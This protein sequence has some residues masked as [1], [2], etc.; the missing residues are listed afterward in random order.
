MY[1]SARPTCSEPQAQAHHVG[2]RKPEDGAQG[3]AF[4][5]AWNRGRHAITRSLMAV[6]ILCPLLPS[7]V[8]GQAITQGEVLGLSRAI[9]IALK[10]QPTL[11][12]GAYTIKANEALIGQ[13]RSSYYP[14]V[15]T[16]MVFTRVSP[17]SSGARATIATTTTGTTAVSSSSNT[18]S[19]GVT[20][21][22]S[23]RAA[24][25]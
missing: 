8:S 12:A 19:G 25:T 5:K 22:I 17:P 14:Q 16:S 9:E 1:L 21:T 2:L 13:A 6:L 10:N 7:A 3:R 11:M 23:I 15:G 4:A 20:P 24:R 18:A